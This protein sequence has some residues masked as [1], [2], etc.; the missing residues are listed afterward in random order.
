MSTV[1]QIKEQIQTL[2]DKLHKIQSKCSHPNGAVTIVYKSNT[3]NYDPSQDC[4]W[5]E[6]HCKL[7]DKDWIEDQ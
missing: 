5:K 1:I 4:Y 3:G 7:C 2:Q 6:M